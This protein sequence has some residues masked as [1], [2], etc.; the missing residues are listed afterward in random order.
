ML[1]ATIA[2]A[3][4]TLLVTAALLPGLIP[5]ALRSG[6]LDRPGGR[7]KHDKPVPAIGGIA[8]FLALAAITAWFIP[9][10]PQLVGIAAAVAVIVVAGVADDLFRLRW[11]YRLSAQVLAALIMVYW[12]G[13]R[14]ENLGEVFGPAATSLGA[15]SVPLTVVA[16]VGII[17]ALNM[18]DGVDGLAGL[19]TL[20]ACIMLAGAAVY[21]GNAGLAVAMGLIAGAVCGFLLYNMRTPWNPLARVFLG[22][23]GSELLGLLVACAAFRLTQ[24]PEHPVGVHI[25][26]FLLAPVLIDCLTLMV[27]RMRAGVSPFQGDR[28]HLHHLLLDAGFPAGRVSL[29]IAGVSL[30]IGLTAALAVKADVPAWVFTLVFAAM[31]AAHFLATSDR[32]RFVGWMAGLGRR[33]G[34]V[35]APRPMEAWQIAARAAGAPYRRAADHPLIADAAVPEPGEAEG[36]SAP[37]QTGQAVTPALFESNSSK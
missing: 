17:N 13:V 37:A 27:R 8:I 16:T 7:R 19:L 30:A 4:T 11:P 3:C 6:L 18:A 36:G 14:I 28:N 34:L 22:N 20:A 32:D 12:G 5:I 23:A 15:L 35:P 21:S 10:T 24:N 31:W 29:T 33:A 25:A 9:P 1:L 26:P 2:A